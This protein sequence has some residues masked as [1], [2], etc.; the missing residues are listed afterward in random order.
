MAKKF[1]IFRSWFALL[2]LARPDEVSMI[3]FILGSGLK[4]IC[5]EFLWSAN[6]LEQLIEDTY[7]DFYVGFLLSIFW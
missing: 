1:I 5:F 4:R 7:Y 2:L 3:Y 6:S